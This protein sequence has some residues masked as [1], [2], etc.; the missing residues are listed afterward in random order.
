MFK[1]DAGTCETL[2]RFGHHT[3][4]QSEVSSA[5]LYLLEHQPPN[6]TTF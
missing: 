1:T 5:T 3:G 4:P 2:T 6:H